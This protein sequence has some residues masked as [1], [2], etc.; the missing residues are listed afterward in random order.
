MQIVLSDLFIG[1]PVCSLFS[2]TKCN[3]LLCI[4]PHKP[5]LESVVFPEK[6]LNPDPTTALKSSLTGKDEA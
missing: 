4:I 2:L 3:Q 6:D 1:Q 5:E